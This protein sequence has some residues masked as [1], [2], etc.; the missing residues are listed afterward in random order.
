MPQ[1]V[2]PLCSKRIDEDQYL[3]IQV[4]K[5]ISCKW[6]S[7]TT[8]AYIHY[9]CDH[10]NVHFAIA[11]KIFHM[12]YDAEVIE[13]MLDLAVEHLIRHPSCNTY[14]EPEKWYFYYDPDTV[15]QEKSSPEFVNLAQNLHD[16]PTQAVDVAHRTLMNLAVQFPHY[17][18]T[19][20]LDFTDHRL[21]FDRDGSN[22]NTM[23]ILPLLEDFQYIK[24]SIADSLDFFTI[25]AFG[26]QKLD[27]FRKQEQTV[28]QGF[29][30]MAFHEEAKPIRES[31]RK[32]LTGMGYQAIILD[33]KEHNNQIVPEIFY[34][35]KRSKF[36]V[37][38]VTYPNYGAYYEAGYAQA[39][40][41]QVIICCRED[42]YQDNTQHPHFDIAQQ[43]I[44]VWKDHGELVE[45]LKRRIEVTV[46]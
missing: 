37:V 6:E 25:T 22:A 43:S 44:I 26:W 2:C 27:E 24:R 14:D 41:K 42:V 11:R 18:H 1:F 40:G 19:I 29:V 32:A 17:G 33:E 13:R 28:R 15:Y 21:G 36:V 12:Q 30:A 35:I 38:D 10:Y 46:Q 34:E 4:R 3:R 39:L 8:G 5:G 16:Y 45:R 9:Y 23:G 20:H 7:D 31:F